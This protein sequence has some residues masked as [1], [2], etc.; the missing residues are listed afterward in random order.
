MPD[1]HWGYGF[2]IGGVA[3]TDYDEGVVS[4]GGVGYDINCGVRIIRTA[5]EKKDIEANLES[6]L[7]NLFNHIPTGV[8]SAGAISRLS[9]QDVKRLLKS[10]SRWAIEQGFGQDSDLEYTEENGCMEGADPSLVS[11]RAIERGRPQVGTLGSGNH[12]LEIDLV[13]QVYREDIA[14]VLG[15][16]QGQIVLQIHTGSRG[17]GYQICDDYL[18]ILGKAGSK[19]G[20]NIPDRQ[21]T[22]A[23]IR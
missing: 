21:L 6:L 7:T 23:P 15:I 13:D 22:C 11:Q 3:A 9:G 5:L 1:I 12:F 16:F 18:R 10:G 19:F 14:S 4:P 20:F 2:P 8:G 17:C